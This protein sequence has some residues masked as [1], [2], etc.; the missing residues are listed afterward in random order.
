MPKKKARQRAIDWAIDD[1]LPFSTS[2]KKNKSI[3]VPSRNYY[4]VPEDYPTF[5]KECCR[6]RSGNKVIPFMPFDYQIELSNIIDNHRG[7]MVYKTRQI[8]CTEAIAGK[9]LH[10]AFL[11]PAYAAAVLSIGQTESS[12]VAVRIQ[13]MPAKINSLT[14]LTKSKTEVQPNHCGKIWFRPSTDNAARSFESIS[15]L[16]FD[17]FAFVD[18]AE[19]LYSSAVPTQEAVGDEAKTIIAS[20]MSEMGKL[21]RF[22]Q[23]FDADNPCDAEEIILKMREGTGEPF[24]WWT[25]KNGWAK[26]IV[27]WRSQPFY[28]QIPDYLQRTKEKHKLTEDKLQREYNLGIPAAGGCLFVPEMVDKCAIGEWKHPDRDRKYLACIDPNF[29]GSDYWV[30]QIWDITELPYSLVHQYREQEKSTTYSQEKTLVLLDS[31][32][33]VLTAIEGNSGGAVLA[34]NIAKARPNLRLETVLTSRTSKRQNT[35]RIAIAVEEQQVIYPQ[36]WEG[37]LEM[38]RFSSKNREAMSG[39]DDTIMAWAA[40]WAWLE[41]AL[42]LARSQYVSGLTMVKQR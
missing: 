11:N 9:F 41:E 14:Y 37:V 36:I 32:Q 17:E 40:G 7:I 34:E 13:N 22:W 31:Y 6:I 1:F 18:N 10:K 2:E 42:T 8:G 4:N 15:D 23:M 12:N 19:E 20:T 30:T 26:A 3:I 21:S 39:H 24:V 33:P 35:D 25:D 29:G 5:L 28:A 16:F 38:K 27:H